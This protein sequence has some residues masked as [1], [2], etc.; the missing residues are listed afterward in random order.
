MKCKEARKFISPY[1]DNELSQTDKPAF[2]AHIET[3]AVCEQELEETKS[4]DHMFEAS[5][6]F[7]APVGL[8][9]RVMAGVEETETQ[10]FWK[11]FAARP[12][13]LKAIEV[14][15]ALVIVI[16]GILSGNVLVTDRTAPLRVAEL[17]GSFHLDVFEPA[18]PDS[19]GGIYVS[20]TGVRDE[21]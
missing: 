15:F 12:F 19:I 16:I 9:T 7:S 20:M 8:A 10:G 11:V 2:T 18:P 5:E 4:L 6:R 1:I 13:F 3:C 17:R 21:R 14:A